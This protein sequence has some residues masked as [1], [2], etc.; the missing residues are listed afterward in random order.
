MKLKVIFT[1]LVVGLLTVL[2]CKKDKDDDPINNL[3]PYNPTP[4][5]INTPSNLP[6]MNVPSF[7]PTT[8][9]GVYLGRKLYYDKLLHPTGTSSCSSCHIQSQGFAVTGTNIIPHVNLGY[10]NKFLWNGEIQGT[11][12]DAMMFEVETFLAQMFQDFRKIVYILFFFIKHL[13]VQLLILKSVLMP[14]HSF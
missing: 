6:A 7:N 14:W 2:A 13:A 3:P 12:E 9:E 1:V 4:Y 10:Q 8:V 5:T 11:L